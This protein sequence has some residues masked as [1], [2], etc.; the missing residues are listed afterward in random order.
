[1]SR[2]VEP[3]PI[4]VPG[5]EIAGFRVLADLGT[6]AA[7]QLYL[8]QDP[9]TKHIWALKHVKKENEKDQRYLDQT[10][11]EYN[12]G[13][14]LNHPNIRKV[15]RLT[16][17]RKVIRVTEMFMT[18]EFVD[19]IAMDQHPPETLIDALDI[20]QQAAEGLLYMHNKGF[21]HADIKPNNIIVTENGLAKIIDLGQSCRIGTKKQRIQGT[22]DYIAP[23]QVHRREITPATD[24]Y[25]LGATIYWAITGTT[26]PTAMTDRTGLGFA[27]EASQ[28]ERPKP[29]IQINPQIPLELSELTL[30]CVEP[31]PNKR[32]PMETVRNRLQ[33]IQLKLENAILNKVDNPTKSNNNH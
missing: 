11:A 27:K 6:G 3:V 18:L 1:M 16:K 9:K 23:E 14:Q 24:V 20:L 2:S 32:P 13:S 5:T 33:I 30:E 22:V 4:I 12:V 7:S 8:V 28:I 19:G 25:N 26:I 10:E 17:N 31:D 15:A 29:P 21:V